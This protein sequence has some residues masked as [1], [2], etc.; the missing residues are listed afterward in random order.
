MASTKARPRRR[1]WTVIL[2]YP[3]Y[4]CDDFGSD[5]FV[6]WALTPSAEA[7]VPIV[8]RKAVEAQRD[9]S[10]GASDALDDPEDFKMIA[11]WRGRT[12]LTLDAYS[13]L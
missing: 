2:L 8:Q 1:W 5:L 10:H 3:T 4:L 9:L 13:A 6:E 11:V 7:A 12:T